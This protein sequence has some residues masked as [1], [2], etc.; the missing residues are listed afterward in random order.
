M[1]TIDFPGSDK[2]IH[3]LD[4]ALRQ[5]TT[6][7]ITDSI[8]RSLCRLMH[9]DSVQLPACVFESSD[10]HYARREL[11]RSEDHGYSV[12]AM[13]WAPGQGAPVHDHDGLWCVEGVWHGALEITQYELL[14][15]DHDRYRLNPV[16]AIEAGTGSAGSLIPPHEYHAIGNPRSRGTAVSLHVY[17]AP[18]TRCAVFQPIDDTWYRRDE[19]QLS[20]DRLH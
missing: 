13:T 8:R 10:T 2:L 15:R 16:G 7:A 12:T 19:K 3:A 4:D 6:T 1:L 11:Y 5:D 9:E 17:S 18:M 20:L 14:E